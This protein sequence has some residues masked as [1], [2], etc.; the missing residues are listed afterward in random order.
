MIIATWGNKVFKVSS[1][2][3]NTFSG[4]SRKSSISTEEQENGNKKPKLKNKAPT[5]ETMSFKEDLKYQFCDVLKEINSWINEKGK[6]YYFILG[7]SQYG[8]NKWELIDIDVSNQVIGVDGIL[9]S[10]TLSLSFKEKVVS[11][12]SNKTA[13]Q[14]RNLK[15]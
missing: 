9:R 2:K 10:A 8:T 14:T 3:V 15:G 12:S 11:K 7:S 5:L 13:K 6:Y 1:D 4:L